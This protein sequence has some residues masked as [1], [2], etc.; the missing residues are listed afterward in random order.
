MPMVA[1]KRDAQWAQGSLLGGARIDY[2]VLLRLGRL[3]PVEI[4]KCLVSHAHEYL[5]KDAG[6]E[7]TESKIIQTYKIHCGSGAWNSK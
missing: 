2:A 5:G 7:L 4:E 1:A 3:P 6:A